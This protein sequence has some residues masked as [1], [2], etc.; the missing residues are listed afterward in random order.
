MYL[1]TSNAESCDEDDEEVDESVVEEE[2]AGKPGPQSYLVGFIAI[3]S[4]AVC[5]EMWILTAFPMIRIPMF[6][7]ESPQRKHCMSFLKKHYCD[8]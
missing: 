8:E 3:N 5:D 7:A 1:L 2:L 4:L 6:L